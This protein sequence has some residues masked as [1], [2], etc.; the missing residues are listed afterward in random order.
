MKDTIEEAQKLYNTGK[1][2]ECRAMY[3]RIAEGPFD[4]RDRGMAASMLVH[5]YGRGM[6]IPEN[7]TLSDEWLSKGTALRCP[8]SLFFLYMQDTDMESREFENFMK[9][10]RNLAKEGST[11]AMQELGLIYEMGFHRK[12]DLKKALSWYEKAGDLGDASSMLQAGWLLDDE[13]SFLYDAHRAYL[14]FLKGAALGFSGT[15][16]ELGYCYWQERGVDRDEDK[17][18]TLFERAA[19]H[20]NREACGTLWQMYAREGRTDEKGHV[21]YDK[22]KAFRYLK[23]GVERGDQDGIMVLAMCY[24]MGEGTPKNPEKAFSLYQEAWDQG[25]A[26]AGAMMGTMYVNGLLGEENREKGIAYLKES[27]SEGC[28]DAVRELGSC[29]LE[30]KGVLP[31]EEEG[32]SLLREAAEEGDGESY[33]RI[34]CHYLEEKDAAR[35]YDAFVKAEGLGNG[36]GEF[37]LACFYL[38]GTV[39]PR[40]LRRAEELFRRSAE[41]GVQ[42]AVNM[43]KENFYRE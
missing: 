38:H 8:L 6:G 33:T 24:L 2:T 36:N 27:A 28:L 32:L 34:G 15:E 3:Q 29:Y 37:Y 7:G 35:A 19:D 17:A 43:L 20:G 26:M 41:K 31:D 5:I 30:G 39:V 12:K 23:M 9:K 22:E 14:W 1:Y 16:Y 4:D 25:D 42:A 21:H 11:L 13:S 40:N 18:L 10:I